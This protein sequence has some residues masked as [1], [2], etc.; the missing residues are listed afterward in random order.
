MCIR[1]SYNANVNV[2]GGTKFVKYFASADFVHEGDL[3][4]EYDNGRN[5]NSGY[6]YN[7]INVRSN[8]DFAITSSTT[9]KVNVAA[10]SY[11]HLVWGYEGYEVYIINGTF[12]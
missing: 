4:R 1:D 9:L 10:V 6:G 3:V 8:L 12:K 5:Y 11:T 7:R 2:S